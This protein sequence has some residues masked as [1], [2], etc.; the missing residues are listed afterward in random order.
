M[1]EYCALLARRLGLNEAR[2]ELIRIASPMHDVG[3]IGVPD[4]ILF[5]QGPLNH[6]ELAIVRRH[7]DLGY[8]I[9]SGT[10]SELLDLAALIALTHHEKHD[11]TGYPRGLAR[12]EIP[13][14]GRIAAIADVF[15]ALTTPRV[16]KL[17]WTANDAAGVIRESSGKMFDPEIVR[18]FESL[19]ARGA[20]PKS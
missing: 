7:P 4:H 13:I 20:F 14:E 17:A 6:D 15:D 19:F 11:G 2:C 8:R 18:A 1:A 10:G 3:K 16:Y 5:K 9:L 12:E